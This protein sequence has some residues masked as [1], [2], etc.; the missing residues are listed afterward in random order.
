MSD[1]ATVCSGVGVYQEIARRIKAID[2]IPENRARCEVFTRGNTDDGV[3]IV[4]A[5]FDKV[6]IHN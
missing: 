1:D 3:G 6:V 2:I 5:Q 4:H